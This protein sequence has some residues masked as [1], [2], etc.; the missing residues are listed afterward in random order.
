MWYSSV[1]KS[2][3]APY[4]ALFTVLKWSANGKE[5]VSDT[6]TP[7]RGERGAEQKFFT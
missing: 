7:L 6:S 3:S 1:I 2:R 5:G 4:V